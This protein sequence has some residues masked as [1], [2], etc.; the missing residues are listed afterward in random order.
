MIYMEDRNTIA[1]LKNALG[2]ANNAAAGGE[3]SALKLA[4]I[5]RAI[6]QVQIELTQISTPSPVPVPSK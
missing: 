4:D 5:V 3:S 1:F 6:Y 2:V